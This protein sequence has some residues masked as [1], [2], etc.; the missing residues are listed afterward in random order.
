M[1]KKL[2]LI[3]ASAISAFAMHTAEINI[4]D[5]DLELGANIDMGQMIDT[6]EPNTT[7]VGMRYLN[8]S[9]ENSDV[10]EL[11][12]YIEASFLMKREISDTGISFGIGVKTNYTRVLGKTYSTVPLGLE[13]GYTFPIDLPV[14]LDAQVYYAPSSLAFSNADSFLQYRASA[15]VEVIENGSLVVGY[16]NM[17]TNLNNISNDITYNS[18]AYFGFRFAF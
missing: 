9:D 10:R 17:Q 16:R 13:V 4:N 11:D 1:L 15:S 2:T 8:A 18:S 7:F 3:S 14:T 5:K 6:V 12:D